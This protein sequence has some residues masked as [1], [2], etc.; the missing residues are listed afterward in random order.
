MPRM[1]WEIIALALTIAF[2]LV[3]KPRFPPE[4]PPEPIVSKYDQHLEEMRKSRV[5]EFGED[6]DKRTMQQME[7]ERHR[8]GRKRKP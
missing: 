2:G 3:R 4:K 1:L 6:W 7:S 8:R 5:P